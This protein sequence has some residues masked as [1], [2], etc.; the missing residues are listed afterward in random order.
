MSQIPSPKPQAADGPMPAHVRKSGASKKRRRLAKM[1]LG[2]FA[3]G[4]SIAAVAV[5]AVGL[6]TAPAPVA[7]NGASRAE[8]NGV[9]TIVLTEALIG[10]IAL[11]VISLLTVRAL[12]ANPVRNLRTE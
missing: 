9:G 1:S 8:P 7:E 4:A 10:G 2:V 12:I 3:V 11:G 6:S 5:F